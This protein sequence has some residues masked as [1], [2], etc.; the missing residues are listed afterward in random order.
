MNKIGKFLIAAICGFA[1]FGACAEGNYAFTY[2]A[3]L[4]GEHGETLETRNHQVKLRLYTQASGGTAVWGRLCSVYTDAN[5]LFNLEVSDAS[6][7][8]IDGVADNTLESVFTANAAGGVYVGLEVVG[9]AGE[10]VPRQRLFAVPFAAVAND[11]RAINHDI[12]VTGN[13]TVGSGSTGVVITPS[14]IDQ[15]S[16]T[17]SFADLEVNGSASIVGTATIAG[18]LTVNGGKTE[19]KSDVNVAS[20]NTLSI[21]GS[22]VVP[23]PVGGIIMWT[24]AALPDNEHW[25]ICNGQNGTPDLRNRFVVGSADA[26]GLGKT[27]GAETVTLSENQI[28]AH[29]HLYAGDDQ[30]EGLEGGDLNDAASCTVRRYGTDRKYDAY[31]ERNGNSGVYYTSVNTA[32]I[33]SGSAGAHPI[34]AT[35]SHENRPPFYSLYFIMRIK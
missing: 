7:S 12:S 34:N 14:G 28:P 30:L 2:Q 10:I 32:A 35:A 24:K 3:A 21:A 26:S 4:K 19:F 22:E 17:G 13:I 23:V 9:S 33:G 25:A 27:G 5:G 16:G 18:G 6:G 31:S 11:V 1:L 20:G 15:K 29:R 8:K